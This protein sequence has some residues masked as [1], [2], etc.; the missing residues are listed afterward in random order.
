[1][2]SIVGL[3]YGQS[4]TGY[5]LENVTNN[6]EDTI[7]MSLRAG[8][9]GSP[10]GSMNSTTTSPPSY[11]WLDA[12][13]YCNPNSYGTN[14]TVC[15]TFTPSSSSVTINSGYSQTGC[16]NVSF[17]PFNLY[18]ASCTLIGTGLNFT[19]LVPGNS[20]VWC[21]TA[22]ASGGGPSCTGFNDFCP[23]FFNNIVLP[24]E[25]GIFFGYSYEGKSILKWTTFSENNNDYFT[26]ERSIDSENW[27]QLGNVEGA[28]YSTS[29]IDYTYYDNHPLTGVNYYRLKQ[30]DFDGKY[31]Y[32]NI[33]PIIHKESKKKLIK[34]VN[35]TVQIVTEEYEGVK[36]FIYDD[37][38]VEQKVII[39]Q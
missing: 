36:Y 19:S 9:C 39:K 3:G 16:V 31:Q 5:V 17:G 4:Y 2:I 23:Y 8:S 12:N 38:T 24:V 18:D 32:F 7:Y 22:S 25:L 29:G 35:V 20:Y 34:I 21:M 27:T 10:D 6:T 30:T 26:V 14:P 13:G 37:G 33:I 11:N 1:M 15:W 28:G